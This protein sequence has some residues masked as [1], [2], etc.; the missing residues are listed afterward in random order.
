V[1]A[2][3]ISVV[4]GSDVHMCGSGDGVVR[5]NVSMF[6]C[7]D[8]SFNAVVNSLMDFLNIP[9][10]VV[11]KS[12]HDEPDYVFLRALGGKSTFEEFCSYAVL[13]NNTPKGR[14]V[15]KYADAL[16]KK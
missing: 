2:L 4:D 7:I 13:A 16:F 15:S 14:W 3:G 9:C 6:I 10:E 1:V 11:L 8:P 12:R 5:N